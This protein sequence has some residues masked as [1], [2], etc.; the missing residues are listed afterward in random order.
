MKYGITPGTFVNSFESVVKTIDKPMSYKVNRWFVKQVYKFVKEN[1]EK[2]SLREYFE[3]KSEY[4]AKGYNF[5]VDM[6]ELFVEKHFNW[7]NR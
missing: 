6:I 4:Q 1:G 7:S 5:D 3:S 2:Q